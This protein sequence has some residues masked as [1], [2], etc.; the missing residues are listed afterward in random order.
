MNLLRCSFFWVVFLCVE[1]RESE[2]GVVWSGECGNL[3]G[4]DGMNQRGGKAR[5]V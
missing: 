4:S 3:V 5:S 2:L 1:G